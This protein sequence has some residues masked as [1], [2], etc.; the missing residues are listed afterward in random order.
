[1][2][3]DK[4]HPFKLALSGAYLA[5]QSELRIVQSALEFAAYNVTETLK[6]KLVS[7]KFPLNNRCQPDEPRRSTRPRKYDLLQPSNQAGS[8]KIY[9]ARPLLNVAAGGNFTAAITQQLHKPGKVIAVRLFP[10]VY[11]F[12]GP[13]ECRLRV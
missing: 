4:A 9:D 8:I 2:F 1:M 12:P 5:F 13:V 3:V 6:S 10:L 7:I 11:R